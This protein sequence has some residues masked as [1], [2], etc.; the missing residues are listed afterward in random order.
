MV[1]LITLAASLAGISSSRQVTHL[2]LDSISLGPETGERGR[3]GGG[4]VA[5]GL[6]DLSSRSNPRIGLAPSSGGGV[7]GGGGGALPPWDDDGP[8]RLPLRA[9]APSDSL[10]GGFS[11][12]RN[13]G[14]LC[15]GSLCDNVLFSSTAGLVEEVFATCRDAPSIGCLTDTVSI[16][17]SASARSIFLL[18]SFVSTGFS[19]PRRLRGGEDGET[20]RGTDLVLGLLS[21]VVEVAAAVV[22]VEVVMIAGVL[23]EL[24]EP[25]VLIVVA[26]V[27]P[28]G[29]NFLRETLS[30]AGTLSGDGALS[31]LSNRAAFSSLPAS[32]AARSSRFL[33]F[34]RQ[35]PHESADS[36]D[37]CSWR[38]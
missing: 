26:W 36:A 5:H 2:I 15:D 16:R 27:R 6:S 20:A 31:D 24:V 4:G 11:D 14:S 3:R 8:E 17:G 21:V 19:A 9:D 1:S 25:V 32:S 13:V 30:G 33:C 10:R 29:R 22:V 35:R 38:W 12:G 7:G 28:S 37:E 23:V 18:L 34:F